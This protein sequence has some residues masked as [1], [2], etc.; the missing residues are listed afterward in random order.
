MK[1]YRVILPAALGAAVLLNAA[2]V[3]AQPPAQVDPGGAPIE[4][5]V[6]TLDD[7]LAQTAAQNEEWKITEA[8]I[9]QAR[10]ARRQALAALLPSVAL[11]ASG[12]RN[13]QEISFGGRQ[14][15][16]QYDWN[17]S[18]S[19]SVVIFDGTQY[20]L[21]SRAGHLLDATEALSKWQRRTLLFEATQSFYLLAAAQDRVSISERTVELRKAQLDRA[22]AMLDA[23]LAVKLDVERAK[24]QYLEAKQDLLGAQAARGD[25]DDAL[26]SILALDPRVELQ[27]KVADTTLATPPAQ[28]PPTHLQKRADFQAVQ[29]QI[30]AVESSKT[31][32]WW[33][34]FPMVEL[35]ADARSGPKSAF[36]NPDGFTWSLTLSA[37]WLLYDG[38]ARFAQLDQLQAQVDEQ[39][40][41]YQRDL[42]DAEVGV[43]R[44][45]RDWKTAVAAVSVA[46]QQVES[47]KQ[48]Y[49]SASQRFEHGLNTSVDVADA[50]QRLYD[51]QI[52]LNQRTFE[53]RNARA[54]Y[55][56]L[57]GLVG[58]D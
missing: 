27:A 4:R 5:R 35:S 3:W 48:A 49:E 9:E 54:N 26:G 44:A 32:V 25:A 2:P 51:A 22:Q 18:G 1:M 50:A 21:L 41:S 45:L 33:S 11:R 20:P 58:E 7:V 46:R 28:A 53:A 30:D 8:R 24:T 31:S 52:S 38:G 14:V 43:R 17:A 56:Y 40:L 34:F 57:V 47:A 19:A 23:K 6:V 29:Q 13:G 39:K 36:S 15:R 16:P 12:T 55:Q 42:R 37:T 10:A